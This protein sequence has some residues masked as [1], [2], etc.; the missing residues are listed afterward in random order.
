MTLRTRILTGFLAILV[1]FALTTGF[2]VSRLATLRDDLRLIHKGYLTMSRLALQVR[3]LQ[4]AK[5]EYVLRSVSETDPVVRRHLVAYARAFYPKALR[6]RL[7]ELEA[8]ANSIAST[9]KEGRAALF[10]IQDQIVRARALH[11]AYD[12]ATLALLERVEAPEL[13][14]ADPIIDAYRARGLALSDEVRALSVRVEAK[15]ADSVLQAETSGREAV[16]ALALL[17]LLTLAIGF[18]VLVG[19]QRGLHPL[20]SLLNSARAIGRGSLDVE[21]PLEGSGEVRELATEFNAMARALRERER[22]FS[23]QNDDIERLRAFSDDVIRSVRVG[24]VVI[25]DGDRIMRLNPAARAVFA[26]PLVDVEGRRISDVSAFAGPLA[27]ALDALQNVRERHQERAFP[28]VHIGER[29]VDVALVPI[30]DRAGASGGLVLL[31]GED[32]T[33]REEARGRLVESE[34][35]AAIGRL[36][37][38]ITHEIRNP[39]SSIGLNVELLADDIPHLPDERRTETRAI[40]DAVAKEVDRLSQITEG[41]LRYAR[42]PAPRHESGDVGDVVADLAAF[43]QSEAE[44]LDVNI[45]LQIEENLPLVPHDASRVR[46]AL[47]NLLRNGFEA[48]GKGGTVRITVRAHDGGVRIAVLDSGPGIAADVRTRVFE[49]FFTT[50]ASGTGLGLTLTREIV[51]AHGGELSLV[52]S[53]LGGAGFA[54]DLPLRT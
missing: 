46:Q 28:L 4:E 47:L 8:I 23:A 31:L 38:Q 6:D 10:A 36:A 52:D 37:A 24:I 35:L 20:S 42:L 48:A 15:L 41:Y 43:S 2:T 45:E 21:V 9:T 19:V 16:L 44:R 40:L 27:I 33:A 50:K 5:D 3:T 32:V 34:R 25:D 7:S 11:D 22:A 1:A 51:R 49:P 18:T 12:E 14:V 29:V 26:L 53:P 13:D 30:R 17:S 54:M 39:L